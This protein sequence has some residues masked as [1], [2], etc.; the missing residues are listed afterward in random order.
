[1]T[2]N[3]PTTPPVGATATVSHQVSDADT[4]H[5]L[6]TGNVP[7]LASSRL[8]TWSEQATC[9]A[10]DAHLDDA[11]TSVGTRL[12]V[13]HR[14]PSPLH[15]EVWVHARLVDVDGRQLEFEVHAEH[16]DG[17]V[18]GRGA[19]TRMLVDRERFL[20]KVAPAG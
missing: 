2:V 16:A 7:V 8:L 14:Q 19:V 5:T 10:V 9:A 11:H 4:A 15:T 3:D 18:V 1:M 12:Q 17:Q 6:G 13:D 20:Q